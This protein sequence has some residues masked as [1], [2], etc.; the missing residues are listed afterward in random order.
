MEEKTENN[1]LEKFLP[2]WYL[3]MKKWILIDKKIN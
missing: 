1:E 3:D 2:K